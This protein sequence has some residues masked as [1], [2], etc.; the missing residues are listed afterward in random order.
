MMNE[1]CDS[2]AGVRP[3]ARLTSRESQ[4]LDLLVQGYTSQQVAESLGIRFYTVTT[5]LKKIYRKMGVHN[6]AAV[7]SKSLGGPIASMP[8]M[9]KTGYGRRTKRGVKCNS[10]R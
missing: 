9:P 4:V 6:R 10:R 3:P 1:Q 7:V 5:H 8:G 2:S